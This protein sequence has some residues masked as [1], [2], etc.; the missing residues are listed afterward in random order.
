MLNSFF[1]LLANLEHL[2]NAS[3]LV[4]Y[5]KARFPPPHII[6]SSII[7]FFFLG[8]EEKSATFN[9]K[10]R[11]LYK[12]LNFYYG[13]ISTGT[14]PH[15]TCINENIPHTNLGNIYYF[16]TT[17]KVI[18]YHIK[19]AEILRERESMLTW[20]RSHSK[21]KDVCEKPA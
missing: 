5:C 10:Q 2:I 1:C 4:I 7:F 12:L 17:P 11:R 16:K 19:D 9:K 15:L 6:P 3:G 18:L 21:S 8:Q 13:K 20:Y 14:F